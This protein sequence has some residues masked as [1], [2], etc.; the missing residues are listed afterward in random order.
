MAEIR[1]NNAQRIRAAVSDLKLC[2]KSLIMF[3]SLYF[4]IFYKKTQLPKRQQ[5]SALDVVINPI[6]LWG[7]GDDVSFC[8][9]AAV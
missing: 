3:I 8:E 5:G 9:D 1:M 6:S 4:A 2:E 7:D